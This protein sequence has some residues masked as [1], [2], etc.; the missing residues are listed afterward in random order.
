MAFSG[1]NKNYGLGPAGDFDLEQ[2]FYDDQFA[3]A[4]QVSQFGASQSREFAASLERVDAERRS[5]DTEKARLAMTPGVTRGGSTSTRSVADSPLMQ[6]ATQRFD[7]GGQTYSYDPIAAGEQEGAAAGAKTTSADAARYQALQKIPGIR[8]RDAAKMVYGRTLYDDQDAS[9]MN[10]AVSRYA[11]DKT[12]E[13][14]QRALQTGA[15][16]NEFQGMPRFDPKTGRAVEQPMAP[17]PGTPEYDAFQQRQMDMAEQEREKVVRLQ[18]Q[19]RSASA[20][21]KSMTGRQTAITKKEQA[22]GLMQQFNGDRAAAESSAE[23]QRM[24]IT[25]DDLFLAE[26]EYRKQAAAQAGRLTTSSVAAS[27]E[28]AAAMVPRLRPQ[29]TATPAQ[30]HWDLVKKVI[31]D[32]RAAGES[33]TTDQ[34]RFLQTPRP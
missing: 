33:L 34:E 30:K 12:Q 24:G 31:D 19:E 7:I 15:R 8:P 2:K 13:N 27:P 17:V 32:K 3:R 29:A 22:A 10:Q 20:P 11:G 23:A 14:Y 28:A 18:A 5:S 26:G 16:A 6:G 25:A 1:P 21:A 9:E 4:M